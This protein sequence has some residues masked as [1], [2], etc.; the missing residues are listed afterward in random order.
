MI[1]SDIMTHRPVTIRPESR[2][3]TALELMERMECH[4]LP[5][6]SAAG[7]LVGILSDRDCRTALHS[8]FILRERWQDEQLIDSVLVGSIMTPAPIVTEPSTFIA[9]ATRLM[10]VNHIHCLPVMRG[11]TLV[12]IITST[13]ILAAFVSKVLNETA[14]LL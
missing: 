8:P 4:H 7:H 2:L 6:V 10:L 3:R 13:D 14:P 11:E 1:V 9:E 5:V 12:G